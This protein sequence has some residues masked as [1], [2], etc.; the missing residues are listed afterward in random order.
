MAISTKDAWKHIRDRKTF[1]THG[2]L[3]GTPDAEYHTARL[4]KHDSAEY[5][6]NIDD[7]DFVVLSYAT[8]IAWHYRSSDKWF[9]VR[10]K[11]SIT[12]SKHQTQIGK[13]FI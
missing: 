4:N 5:L 7:I 6:K 9:V 2:S 11:F 8:P 10:E 13:A 1:K 3:A 12:T